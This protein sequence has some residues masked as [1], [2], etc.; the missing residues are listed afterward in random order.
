MIYIGTSTRNDLTRRSMTFRTMIFPP[1]FGLPMAH[2]PWSGEDKYQGTRCRHG[3][4]FLGRPSPRRCW[5][6]HH[7]SID[8]ISRRSVPPLTQESV[9]LPLPPPDPPPPPW[10][11]LVN[12]SFPSPNTWTEALPIESPAV[13]LTVHASSTAP[14]RPITEGSGK[15]P[16]ERILRARTITRISFSSPPDIPTTS[17][18]RTSIVVPTTTTTTATQRSSSTNATLLSLAICLLCSRSASFPP[19]RRSKSKRL[20]TSS[21]FGTGGLPFRSRRRFLSQ[22]PVYRR[23]LSARRLLK[24]TPYRLSRALLQ[25]H[26]VNLATDVDATPLLTAVSRGNASLPL[27]FSLAFS[28]VPSVTETFSST[29]L[30]FMSMPSATRVP[31]KTTKQQK[32]V[33]SNPP[34][35]AAL[36]GNVASVSS[37]RSLE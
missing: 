30:S 4:C 37:P 17:R 5:R 27:K 1:P 28:T 6:L 34:K 8:D 31:T 19:T 21:G 12:F 33:F 16:A 13:D 29:N 23:S 26:H 24:E 18:F 36:E 9:E 35:K 3:C 22:R 32:L 15:Q 25:S 11:F 2:P 7:G 10:P 14:T 20:S